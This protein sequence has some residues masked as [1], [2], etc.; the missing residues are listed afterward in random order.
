V[1]KNKKNIF[2]KSSFSNAKFELLSQGNSLYLK[3]KIIN[4][5][6]RDFESI[7]K[8]NFFLKNFKIK[9]LKINK[10]EIE[11]FK[12]L[13]KKKYFIMNYINGYSSDL[14]LKNLGVNEIKILREF[15]KN[16]FLRL[17]ESTK[18][19]KIE[20][21]F[22]LQ[23]INNVK[24]NIKQK[25]LL[26]LFNDNEKYLFKKLNKIEY[27][28]TG[29]CHGD[30]TLSNMIIKNDKIYL[31][32]FLNTY[33]D[34]IVQDLS[35]IYQEFILG[36]SSRF[37][38][39]NDIVRS[40]IIYENIVDK[41]FFKSFSK[42]MITVLEFEIILTLLRIFPYVKKNDIKTIKWLKESMNKIKKL[43]I[44]LI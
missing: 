43:N 17:K 1:V 26:K 32:D 12:T 18:W 35:K 21:K 14:I 24:K 6:I 4:P 22:F 20:R 30:L 28:P 13:K 42:E 33:K 31:I 38:N 23:K 40:K 19:E 41:K 11:N 37:L 29:I 44:N 39:G 36:W 10:I 27:Y 15:L 9:N 16:Y 3:K 8:N 25:E 7:K 5:N 34:S 2:F